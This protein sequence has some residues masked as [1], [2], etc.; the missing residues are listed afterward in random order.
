MSETELKF[1]KIRLEQINHSKNF[2]KQHSQISE[3]DSELNVQKTCQLCIEP[4]EYFSIGKCNHPICYKCIIR[5][6]LKLEN[7]NCPICRIEL[8]DVYLDKELRDFS[9]CNKRIYKYDRKFSVFLP[10]Y[11]KKI[12]QLL[13][14]LNSFTCFD[15]KCMIN[16]GGGSYKPQ[17]NLPP[18]LEKEIEDKTQPTTDEN[19]NKTKEN[20]KPLKLPSLNKW[21]IHQNHVHKISPC[22]LCIEN[23]SLFC[24]EIQLFNKDELVK[25]I[26]K[27][28]ERCEFCDVRYYDKDTLFRHLRKDHEYCRLC[29]N[30]TSGASLEY[31]PDFKEL[32]I[33]LTEQH[34]Y[35]LHPSCNKNENEYSAFKTEVELQIHTKK[36]HGGDT[37]VHL[38]LG[39]IGSTEDTR[40]EGRNR[41]YANQY[42]YNNEDRRSNNR[43]NNRNNRND[44]DENN[45]NEE[46][47]RQNM[48]PEELEGFNMVS[49][50]E[51]FQ[52]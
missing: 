48:T 52:L 42:Y 38:Q 41:R 30:I 44:V 4:I 27:N 6:R 14:D 47:Q 34:Y 31:Y 12:E 29:E 45:N 37:G 28:H 23:Q 50:D 20:K 10:K 46:N 7:K 40:P 22:N 49:T 1:N 18:G 51:S 13:A 21:K 35:C 5:L 24:H 16:H 26:E 25:H 33:H 19:N 3:S 9:S 15:E 36:D 2:L 43:N 39:G 11:D 8:E 32:R 17:R